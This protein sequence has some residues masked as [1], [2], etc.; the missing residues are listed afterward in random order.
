MTYMS[1][2]HWTE[3]AGGQEEAG[4]KDEKVL[5]RESCMLYG[6]QEK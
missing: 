5:V 2:E 6:I 3:I 1:V 4:T